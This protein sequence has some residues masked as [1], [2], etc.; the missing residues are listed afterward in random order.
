M[1]S[2]STRRTKQNQVKGILLYMDSILIGFEGANWEDLCSSFY[3][4]VEFTLKL[5]LIDVL[6]M[7]VAE[8][9]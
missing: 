6:C 9:S 4:C 8:I 1:T 3:V 2:G 7:H 5:F